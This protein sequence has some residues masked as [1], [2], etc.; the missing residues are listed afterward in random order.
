M[1]GFA[2]RQEGMSETATC[3]DKRSAHP[4]L[5]VQGDT[6]AD[7]PAIDLALKEHQRRVKL[8]EEEQLTKGT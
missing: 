6:Y 2:S 3:R 7:L 4:C 5:Y 8:Q 1:T